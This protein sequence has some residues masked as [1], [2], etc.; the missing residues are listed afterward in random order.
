M[1][2]NHYQKNIKTSLSDIKNKTDKKKMLKFSR[3]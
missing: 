1:L 3:E 2:R